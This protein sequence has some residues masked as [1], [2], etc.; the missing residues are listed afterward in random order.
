MPKELA[1]EEP[2]LHLN[3]PFGPSSL[4]S[5]Y[6]S[7]LA[8]IWFHLHESSPRSGGVGNVKK[9]VDLVDH[10]SYRSSSV[11]LANSAQFNSRADGISRGES[12]EIEGN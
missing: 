12:K 7:R 1:K 5:G 6:E 8:P 4:L 10:H 11:A 3:G 2:E 9:T